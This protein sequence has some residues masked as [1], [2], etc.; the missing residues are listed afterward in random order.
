MLSSN[1]RK[2]LLML[3]FFCSSIAMAQNNTSLSGKDF[4]KNFTIQDTLYQQPLLMLMSGMIN[5]FVTVMCMVA[6]KEVKQG[7]LFIFLPKKNM[8]DASFNTSLLFLTMRI[9]RKAQA[10]KK[11]RLDSLLHMVLILSKQMKAEELTSQNRWLQI[12][13]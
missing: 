12:L 8:R 2:S 4:T 9:Y 6:L 3:F 7:S 11:I 1:L 5:R 13:P 10:E